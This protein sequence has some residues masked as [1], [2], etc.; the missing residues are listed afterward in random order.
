V[1]DSFADLL[2]HMPAIAKAVNQFSSEAVQER[3]F[4]ALMQQLGVNAA[5]ASNGSSAPAASR[6]AKP[7]KAATPSDSEGKGTKPAAGRR[8]ATALSIDKDLNL[9]PA[10]V[11]PF[12][13]FVASKGSPSANAEKLLVTVYWLEKVAEVESVSTNQVYTAFKNVAWKVP[14]DLRNALQQV[15]SKKGW[16]VTTDMDD[17][18]VTIAGENHVEH[19]MKPAA[20]A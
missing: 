14:S 20:A 17:L 13:E 15:A 8:K 18:S 16:L 3:A 7:R 19:D 9:R 1:S 12:A 11:E 5:P 4:D 2:E 6:R 10:G